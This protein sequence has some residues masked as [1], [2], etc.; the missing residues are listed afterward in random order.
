[1]IR[2]AIRFDDPSATSDRCLEERIIET[3]QLSGARICVA[4]I[5]SRRSEGRIIDLSASDV[6]HLIDAERA[7]LIDI[8]QHGHC[9]QPRPA[10]RRPQSEFA[11]VDPRQQALSIVSGREA[12]ETAFGK[13]VRGFVPPWNTFDVNTAELLSK[14]GFSYLSASTDTAECYSSNLAYLPRTC[15]VSALPMV[16][17]ALRRFSAFDPVVIAVMH[18]YDFEESGDPQA[19]MD[20]SS[21]A[22]LMQALASDKMIRFVSLDDLAAERIA[23]PRSRARQRAWQRLP[24]R[25][26]CLL[27]RYAL[28]DQHWLTLLVWTFFH[29][30]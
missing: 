16:I 7:G 29:R 24:W 18:D 26:Q 10:S 11:G 17:P 20:L 23:R 9:H 19:R 12:L 27:P 22:D 2:V 5:P 15:S 30:K 13:S 3:A 14:S 1:M 28:F 6:S 8:A 25:I 4:V 21:F